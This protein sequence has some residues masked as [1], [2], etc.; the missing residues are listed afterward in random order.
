M[1]LCFVKCL[2]AFQKSN[3][4]IMCENVTLTIA[5]Y[6]TIYT[7]LEAVLFTTLV[8]LVYVIT[9]IYTKHKK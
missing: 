2:F 9:E 6:H 8:K 1:F 5:K 3:F 4:I 7:G